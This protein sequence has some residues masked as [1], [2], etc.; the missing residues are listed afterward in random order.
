M[1]KRNKRHSLLKQKHACRFS[2]T[3][4]LSIEETTAPLHQ[5]VHGAR[6]LRRRGHCLIKERMDE[7]KYLRKTSIA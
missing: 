6:D 7:Q 5:F 3:T 1:K 2:E 4:E